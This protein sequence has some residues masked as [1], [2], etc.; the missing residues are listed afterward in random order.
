MIFSEA[1]PMSTGQSVI[2]LVLGFMFATCAE[3]SATDWRV[4]TRSEFG[5]YQYD[6]EDLSPL[7]KSLVRVRQKLVLTDRGTTYLVRELGKEHENV[8]EII[9]L[10]EIDCIGKKTRIL[11]LIYCSENG[12]VINRESYD[13]IEWDS[14][15]S[16]SVDD[17]LYQVVCE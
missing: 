7:S 11:Q 5:L 15:I 2:S 3:V 12:V 8:R 17:I 1:Y 6:A 9:S 16:D 13:P 10:R 14:I 4:Y